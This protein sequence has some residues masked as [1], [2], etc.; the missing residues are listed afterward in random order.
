MKFSF[1]FSAWFVVCAASTLLII[2]APANAGSAFG[3]SETV[4]ADA[5]QQDFNGFSS[6]FVDFVD[7]FEST[8]TSYL[9]AYDFTEE[10]P[11]QVQAFR[12]L[13]GEILFTLQDASS[14]IQSA[15][16]CQ[17]GF[18][19]E[20][21][22]TGDNLSTETLEYAKLT[23]DFVS[24][25]LSNTSSILAKLCDV[26]P[27]FL[28]DCVEVFQPIVLGFQIAKTAADSVKFA[29]ELTLVTA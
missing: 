10:D 17:T 22:V 15:Q 25:T 5:L 19:E 27:G 8:T 7:E 4:S 26:F 21:T 1:V 9:G 13:M 12:A 24:T 2:I 18:V 6:T 28:N 16:A 23:V 14:R 20:G 11:Q 29:I 3:L